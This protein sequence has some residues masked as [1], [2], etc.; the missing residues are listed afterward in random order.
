MCTP[1]FEGTTPFGDIF[2]WPALVDWLVEAS[3]CGRTGG[4]LSF[5][6]TRPGT[7]WILGNYFRS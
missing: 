6:F 4:Q 7:G 5:I 2:D 1:Q 3:N